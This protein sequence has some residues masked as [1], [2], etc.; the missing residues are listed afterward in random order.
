MLKKISYFCFEA[1]YALAPQ[2]PRH[3]SETSLS[4]GLQTRLA[5]CAAMTRGASFSRNRFD[6]RLPEDVLLADTAVDAGALF[7]SNPDCALHVRVSDLRAAS[8]GNWV[9]LAD[10]RIFGRGRFRGRMFCDACGTERG[11]VRLAPALSYFAHAPG[12]ASRE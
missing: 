10:G 9:S 11:P 12:H 4:R 3:A 1:V 7:C 6:C 5:S 2:D 8:A